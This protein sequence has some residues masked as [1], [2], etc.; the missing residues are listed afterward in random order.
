IGKVVKG[1]NAKV[2]I[3]TLNQEFLGKIVII[4]PQADPA[5]KTYSVKVQLKNPGGKL[6]PGMITQTKIS[7]G[8]SVDAL[9]IPATAVI[10]DADDITYVYVADA[11][12]KVIRKRITA[13]GVQGNDVIISEGLQE[14]DKVV[15]TGQTRL[16]DGA[17]VTL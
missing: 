11:N 8:V 3:G 9:T 2:F 16:K 14:G 7:T 12:Q 10:R 13:S 6:L 17:S 1:Q 15:V 4:N 5:T